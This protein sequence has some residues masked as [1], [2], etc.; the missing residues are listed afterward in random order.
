MKL[1][2]FLYMMLLSIP[3]HCT[4]KPTIWLNI[5]IHG[6]I[7]PRLSLSDFFKALNQTSE[8]S[9][10]AE[11]TKLIRM[12]PFFYQAQPIQGL[13]LKKAFPT[14]SKKGRGANIFAEI[15]DKI[16]HLI[17]PHDFETHHYTFGW[18]GLLS[19]KSRR[20]SAQKL[21]EQLA[22]KIKKFQSEGYTIKVRVIGFSHGGTVALYL[23]DEARKHSSPFFV[24][25]LILISTPIQEDTKSYIRSPFF[26]EVY[27]FYSTGDRVQVSDFISSI[28]HS[29]SQ[30]QFLAENQFKLPKKLTQV[31][32]R[33]LRKSF[34]V[35]S[36]NM[37]PK[38]IPSRDYINP[39]HT[40]MFFFGWTAEWYRRHFPIK[41]LSVALL[42]PLIIKEIKEYHLEGKNIRAT[43]IPDEEIVI[44]DIKKDGQKITAPFFTKKQLSEFKNELNK[45]K[46]KDYK[47]IFKKKVKEAKEKARKIFQ[48]K[49]KLKA[50]RTK[51]Q[52]KKPF[53]QPLLPTSVPITSKN[54][55]FAIAAPANP[56]TVM[57]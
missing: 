46:P 57:K 18:S 35:K 44:F 34:T 2:T 11:I 6:T 45:S 16:N 14:K 37:M 38:E 22:Q 15:Y 43:I 25:E 56:T 53:K 17:N 28:T 8:K 19:I 33:F 30:H 32:I 23:A 26:K 20:K 24:Q 31:Q 27:N 40:E 9:I 36:V 50:Q 52:A 5:Y 39:G 47:S 55:S 7:T 42:I 1:I 49:R 3:L 48:T 41:P 54:L 51:L 4:Q 29:F 12:D 10:Y 21:Y 13:G